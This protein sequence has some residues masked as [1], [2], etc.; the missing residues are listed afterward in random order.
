MKSWLEKKDI[1]MCSTN[2]KEK[3][4]VAE[5]FIRTLKINFINT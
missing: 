5:K 2:N 3:S 1:E 4:V